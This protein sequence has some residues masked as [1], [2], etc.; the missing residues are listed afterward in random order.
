MSTENLPDDPTEMHQAIENA[1]FGGTR[2]TQKAQTAYEGITQGWDLP[3][4]YIGDGQSG[5]PVSRFKDSLHES[6]KENAHTGEETLA[7]RLYGTKHPFMA[8]TLAG[9]KYDKGDGV[10]DADNIV[11]HINSATAE[12]E[13]ALIDEGIVGAAAPIEVDPMI[14][15]IQRSNAPILDII[16][17]VAQ[18]GFKAQYN[19]FTGRTLEDWYMSETDASDLSDNTAS[20]FSLG[21]E[22]KDMKIGATVLDVSDFA[23]RA[24][25]SLDYMNVMDTTVGQVMRAIFLTKA[26]TFLYGDPGAGGTGLHENSNAHDGLASFAADAGNVVD[27][28]GTTSGYLEDIL[29]YITQQTQESALTFGNTSV[30]VSPAFYNEIYDEVTPV[31]RLDGYDADVE[32]GPQG[33]AIGHERG[34]VPIRPVDNIRDY[35]SESSGVGSNSTNGDVFLYHEPSIQ[36]RQLA[37]MSTV[38]LGALGLA[39][40]SAVFEY[41]TLIDKSSDP[42]STSGLTHRLRYGSV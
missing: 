28:T 39:D 15:D 9:P 4:T 11:E 24:M 13:R 33:L 36:Y 12:N 42:D 35:S 8:A 18:P 38:P 19:L 7:E 17:S 34:S 41:G 26:K 2:T 31:V 37:P 16:P 29:D 21:T 30:L 1:L 5:V 25:S 10:R 3:E 6:H 23:Q 40:R 14:V 20:D 27:K 22:T 32:Y